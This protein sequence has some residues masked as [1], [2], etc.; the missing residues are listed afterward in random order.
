MV[1]QAVRGGGRTWQGGPDEAV[2]AGVKDAAPV[3]GG[4]APLAL[5][6]GAAIADTPVGSTTGWLTSPLVYGASAQLAA[7]TM[8]GAGAGGLAIVATV[9]AIN[10]R[11][12]Y[13]SA[14]LRQAFR[15]QPRWFRWLG[16]YLLVDPLFALAGARHERTPIPG[17]LRRY[18]LAAG[19]AIWA[20]WLPLVALGIALG[21][22]LPAEA[23]LRFALP[24]MLVGFLVPAVKSRAAG[25]A[26]AVAA[27]V[28]LVAGT[29]GGLGLL[30]AGV[31]GAAAAT[32]IHP[33]RS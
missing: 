5:A 28:V 15:E 13:Y 6:V 8:L 18:Y 4:L 11:A 19:L 26:V 31:C 9:A 7:V 20:T 1:A 30:L 3:I 29:R 16:P 32:L 23:A 21:P 10:A 33:R 24:A 17:D 2:A 27:G 25:T 12:L 22:V 14:A